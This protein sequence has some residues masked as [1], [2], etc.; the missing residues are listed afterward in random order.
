MVKTHW[1]Q[2]YIGNWTVTR[3]SRCSQDAGFCLYKALVPLILSLG[4]GFRLTPASELHCDY[5]IHGSG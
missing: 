1:L 4:T 2:S 3:L 5:G